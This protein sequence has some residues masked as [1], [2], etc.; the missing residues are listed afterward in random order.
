MFQGAVGVISAVGA[1]GS[2][3]EMLKVKISGG[4]AFYFGFLHLKPADS[5]GPDA[6][7]V[8]PQPPGSLLGQSTGSAYWVSLLGQLGGYN[9]HKSAA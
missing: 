9:L 4:C 3:A 8:L 6:H 7:L 1:F 5:Q 2:Q